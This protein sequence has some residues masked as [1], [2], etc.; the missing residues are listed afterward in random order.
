M[1]HTGHS[2]YSGRVGI[3]SLHH[4]LRAPSAGSGRHRAPGAGS[5][6]RLARL[7]ASRVAVYAPR[8]KR[9]TRH[10][11]AS[12]RRSSAILPWHRRPSFPRTGGDPGYRSSA[13]PAAAATAARVV[14]TPSSTHSSAP[15]HL[16][17][18][19]RSLHRSTST[20]SSM[21]TVRRAP[22]QE[23]LAHSVSQL[24]SSAASPESH[25]RRR[26]ASSGPRGSSSPRRHQHASNGTATIW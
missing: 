3:S 9:V 17:P 6:R 2:G 22:R 20:A 25:S 19:L 23:R 24:A 8:A 10:R 21:A 14:V 16:A 11:R 5:G 12:L 13:A 1:C 4:L 15:S 26:A 18:R 7:L